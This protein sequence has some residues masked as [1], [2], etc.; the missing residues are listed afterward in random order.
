MKKDEKKEGIKWQYT[1]MSNHIITELAYFSFPKD[2]LFRNQK[3]K[4]VER[5]Y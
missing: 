4:K 1:L 2:F 3:M 5:N